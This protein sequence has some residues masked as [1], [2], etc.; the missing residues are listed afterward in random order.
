MSKKPAFIKDDKDDVNPDKP[1]LGLEPVM[2]K[3]F[4]EEQ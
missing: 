3:I 4:W 1:P 2:N